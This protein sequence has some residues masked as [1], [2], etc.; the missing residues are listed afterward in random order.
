[1]WCPSQSG[2]N[3]RRERRDERN[4]LVPE[5]P[6]VPSSFFSSLVSRL[7]SLVSPLPSLVS[8]V[9]CPRSVVNHPVVIAPSDL[10]TQFDPFGASPVIVPSTAL[11][12]KSSL[13]RITLR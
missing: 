4:R 8:R 11:P 7:S 13:V 2:I 12:M 5:T 3:E 6:P 10:I 9:Y 1:M